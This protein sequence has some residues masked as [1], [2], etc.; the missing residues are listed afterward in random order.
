MPETPHARRDA[1]R[2][3]GAP[4]DRSDPHVRRAG[5]RVST[6]QTPRPAEPDDSGEWST[7][8]VPQSQYGLDLASAVREARREGLVP[9]A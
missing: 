6:E 5:V 9:D 1:P 2:T 3:P 8:A 7:Q 4:D